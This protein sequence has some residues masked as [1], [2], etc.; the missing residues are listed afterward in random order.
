M[1]VMP[2]IKGPLS[3]ILGA[4]GFTLAYSAM[5]VL[6][7]AW[8]IVAAGRAPYIE[9]WPHLGWMNH[10][11]LTVMALAT[12]VFT[13]SLGRPNP[14]SFGGSNNAAF[15]PAHPG[16]VGWTRHPLLVVLGL[17]SLGHILPNG[18]LAHV[19]MFALFFAF[20][21]MGMKIIDRRKQRLLG[22]AEWQRLSG[23]PREVRP[24]FQTVVRIGLGTGLYAMLL[25]LH[26]PVI[27]VDPL[28]W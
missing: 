22:M 5:S 16:L 23:G 9:L 10:V 6:L 21:L 14:L 11:T 7:L 3:G 4:G 8:I 1:L 13:L 2:R 27:G 17:W 20:S 28:A 26:G 25:W 24:N 12:L 18:D 19:V 15:D